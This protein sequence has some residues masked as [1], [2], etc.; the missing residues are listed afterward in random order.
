MRVTIFGGSG[1]IGRALARR[2]VELGHDVKIIS[3]GRCAASDPRLSCIQANPYDGSQR[4]EHIRGQDAVINLVG[5]LHGRAE[6]FERI[7]IHLAEGI[8]QDCHA[9]RVPRLLHMSAL[10][11]SPDG[12]SLY[13]RSKGLGEARVLALASPMLSITSFR[14]SVV[15]GPEDRFLNTFAKLLAFSPGVLLLPG[16]YARFAPVYLGD[17]V[18]SFVN[19][20]SHEPTEAARSIDL[21][22][23]STYTLLELVRLV[24]TWSGHRR[25]ILPL[26][27]RPARLLAAM[28][29]ILPQPPISRDNLDSMR[30]DSVCAASTECQPTRLESV[31]PTY[32]RRTAA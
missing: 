6:D 19:A 15:F 21:C 17:V 8:A 5:I 32:L 16:A 26:P 29:E 1:F 24:S 27:E 11:A 25:V 4:R 9:E 10:H 2:L 28:M 31:A 23:P 18:Q 20:L 3:R 7:H 30:I 13:L 22:G 14:P 12:P